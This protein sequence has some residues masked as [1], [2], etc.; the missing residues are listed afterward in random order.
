MRVFAWWIQWWWIDPLI[1][2]VLVIILREPFRVGTGADILG[3]L[4]LADRRS[5]YTN[6]LQLAAIFAAFSGAGFL[7][8]LGFSSRG[9]QQI[10]ASAGEALLRVWLA[11]L[12][13]PWVCALVL[14]FCGVTDTG[15]KDSPNLTRWIAM[16][17]LA[18]VVFQLGRVCWVLYEIAMTELGG[19]SVKGAAGTIRVKEPAPKR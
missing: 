15:G 9:V 19:P 10:R 7:I 13:T 11:A 12:V 3:Q 5:T 18:V 14:V 2:A 1:A 16:A 6:M 17:A 4:S 8:Y